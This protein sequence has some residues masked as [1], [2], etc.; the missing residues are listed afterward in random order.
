LGV[1]AYTLTRKAVKHINLRVKRDGSV[2]VSAPY[3]VKQSHIDSFV[4]GKEPWI[5]S[6]QQRLAYTPSVSPIVVSAIKTKMCLQR[7]EPVMADALHMLGQREPVALRIR[8]CKSRW[9]SCQPKKRV[10]MLNRTLYLAPLPLV[11]YVVLH[12]CTHLIVPN[13]G[14]KFQALMRCHMPDYR[15]RRKALRQF[16][17][18]GGL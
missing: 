3:H 5:R 9:G 14:E 2:A 11:E 16:N 12:E 17:P 15:S 18:S 4:A 8:T 10:I 1:M 6:V 7:F 13:H